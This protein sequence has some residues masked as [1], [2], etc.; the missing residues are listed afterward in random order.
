MNRKKD[1]YEKE[2]LKEWKLGRDYKFIASK[3]GVSEP[4]VLNVIDNNKHKLK[5][6]LKTLLHTRNKSHDRQFVMDS[7]AYEDELKGA[8][9]NLK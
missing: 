8:M 2:I 5:K 6:E 3:Y 1:K 9:D 7:Y 4:H